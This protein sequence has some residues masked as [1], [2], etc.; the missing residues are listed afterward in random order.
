MFDQLPAPAPLER[1][2]EGLPG[3]LD[4]ASIEVVLNARDTGGGADVRP[5]LET[6][7]RLVKYLDNVALST[8]RGQNIS[9]VG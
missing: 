2:H 5:E 9:V 6:G 3:D 8:S 4:V 1:D 7:H